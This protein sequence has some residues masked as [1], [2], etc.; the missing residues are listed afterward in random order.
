MEG[1]H[2]VL[3]SWYAPCVHEK[4]NHSALLGTVQFACLAG[5][6]CG[7]ITAYLSWLSSSLV[8][9]KPQQ[10]AV[11]KGGL[12][13][14]NTHLSPAD[15]SLSGHT[16]TPARV[17]SRPW[18]S[19][20][21]AQQ[22]PGITSPRWRDP[23]Y[24]LR[25]CNTSSNTGHHPALPCQS[26]LQQFVRYLPRKC[27]GLVALF[28]LVAYHIKPGKTEMKNWLTE[29]DSAIDGVKIASWIWCLPFCVHTQQTTC[30]CFPS[31]CKAAHFP[32]VWWGEMRYS[33]A[34]KDG[35]SNTAAPS[36]DFHDCSS[37]S[38]LQRQVWSFYTKASHF[39]LLMQTQPI[40]HTTHVHTPTLV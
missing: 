28:F 15:G 22:A 16:V 10:T 35:K 20:Q 1:H 24:G 40:A 27:C 6:P 11:A 31:F 19:P 26:I 38:S 7:L 29:R 17:P 23:F 34:I 32:S 30:F 25:V 14:G 36:S 21:P 33:A 9:E 4:P 37:R 5:S 18:P 12:V 2:P 13:C 8:L 3:M 39:Q